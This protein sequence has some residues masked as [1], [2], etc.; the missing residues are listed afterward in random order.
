MTLKLPK[1][2]LQPGSSGERGIPLHYHYF[3]GHSYVEF[4]QSAVA[5][6]YTDSFSPEGENPPSNECSRCDTQQFDG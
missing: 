2:R 4:A 6:E 1:V 5:L 3:Q